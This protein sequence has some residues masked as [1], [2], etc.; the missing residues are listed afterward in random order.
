M[1][2]K[3][4][5]LSG[6]TFKEGNNKIVMHNKNRKIE[7]VPKLYQALYFVYPHLDKF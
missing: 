6:R 2:G 7:F 5:H 1:S 4:L 3:Q